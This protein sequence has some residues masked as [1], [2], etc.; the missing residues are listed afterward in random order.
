[1]TA[2]ARLA[3]RVRHHLGDAAIALGVRLLHDAGPE[4][5]PDDEA[6]IW[7][8]VQAGRATMDAMRYNMAVA[9][10]DGHG[11]DATRQD[12]GETGDHD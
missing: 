5:T 11:A 7:A 6:R 9:C 1:M 3:R 4:M 12:G 8:G 10:C 2:T